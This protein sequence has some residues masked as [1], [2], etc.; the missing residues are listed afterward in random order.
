MTAPRQPARWWRAT[1]AS[2][3]TTRIRARDHAAATARASATARACKPPARVVAIVLEES[4]DDRA[5]AR[6]RA[7]AAAR[8]G[9]AG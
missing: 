2:G 4:P 5:S 7:A 3:A 1:F 9:W 6:Q 8:A